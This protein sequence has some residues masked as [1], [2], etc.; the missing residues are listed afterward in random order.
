MIQGSAGLANLAWEY[1]S[2][3]RLEEVMPNFDLSSTMAIGA[4]LR[5]L[6]NGGWCKRPQIVSQ[7]RRTPII[8]YRVTTATI[9]LY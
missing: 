6:I 1:A 2:S 8:R 9:S 4:H 7:R 5:A 3:L